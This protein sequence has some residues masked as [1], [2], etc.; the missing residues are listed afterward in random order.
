MRPLTILF[1]NFTP[2][3]SANISC[4]AGTDMAPP[5]KAD[6]HLRD[7]L[8]LWIL[9][10]EEQR[11]KNERVW[12]RRLEVKARVV[13]HTVSELI[14]IG[15]C[16]DEDD[17]VREACEADPLTCSSA[18][19]GMHENCVDVMALID[20]NEPDITC[21]TRLITGHMIAEKC[22]AS[23]AARHN[24]DSA[25]ILAGGWERPEPLL[26]A[27]DDAVIREACEL[28][29]ERCG[30]GTTMGVAHTCAAVLELIGSIPGLSCES[31]LITGQTIG[32]VCCSSCAVRHPSPPTPFGGSDDNEAWNE[33]PACDD[34]DAVIHEACEADREGCGEGTMLGEVRTCADALALMASM[35]GLSCASELIT[36]QTIRK[37]CCASCSLLAG[38]VYHERGTKHVRKPTTPLG[39]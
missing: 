37:A 36:G 31:E 22:C 26:C 17:A 28:D 7:P 18:S 35:P 5:T 19:L 8:Y 11:A 2:I 23:C 27:D 14:S 20:K 21:A 1:V 4:E 25:L 9:Q 16:R 12:Q 29:S 39:P 33:Q 13:V 10:I 15:S 30:E 34:N 24:V 32:E 38:K 3:L 6:S